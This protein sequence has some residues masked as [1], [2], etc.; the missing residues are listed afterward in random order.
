[1]GKKSVLCS[2]ASTL[3][4]LLAIGIILSSTETKTKYRIDGFS[5]GRQPYLQ[6][7]CSR[8]GLGTSE[9]CGATT[10]AMTLKMGKIQQVVD[11]TL[12]TNNEDDFI[13]RDIEAHDSILPTLE[14][15][16]AFSIPT[17]LSTPAPQSSGKSTNGIKR[18]EPR[19]FPIGMIIDQQE[20]KHALLLAAVNPK[21]IGVL[22][23]GGE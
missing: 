18:R 23:S 22:I 10:T 16:S 21:S 6:T 12:K 19:P 11:D 8:I 2:L 4:R 1:M 5:V 3:I 14:E 9:S 17:T 7:R 20:I 13:I 15:I